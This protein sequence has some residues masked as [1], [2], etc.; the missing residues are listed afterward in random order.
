MKIPWHLAVCL[1]RCTE[2]W[3]P[4]VTMGLL[5]TEPSREKESKLSVWSHQH[6]P[7]SQKSMKRMWGNHTIISVG[8]QVEAK[9]PGL[10]SSVEGLEGKINQEMTSCWVTMVDKLL[11]SPSSWF[12]VRHHSCCASEICRRFLRSTCFNFCQIATS[13]SWH[14]RSP[15]LR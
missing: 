5:P 3:Q 7:T 15:I 14:A 4:F 1:T 8:W 2:Q 13:G 10:W 9:R 12:V 6:T 11:R